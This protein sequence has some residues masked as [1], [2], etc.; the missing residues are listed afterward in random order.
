MVFALLARDDQVGMLVPAR[1]VPT[2]CALAVRTVHRHSTLNVRHRRRRPPAGLQ[3]V[4]LSTVFDHGVFE[5]Y[6][7]MLN[8]NWK[9]PRSCHV[10]NQPTVKLDQ[11]SIRRLILDSNSCGKKASDAGIEPAMQSH[12]Q[13]AH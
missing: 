1:G 5:A 4:A 12:K 9:V 3:P 11:C 10:L 13:A 8:Q 7:S 2:L 6:P